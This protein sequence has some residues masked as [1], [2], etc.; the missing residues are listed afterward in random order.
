M[1]D[2][3]LSL[4]KGDVNRLQARVYSIRMSVIPLLQRIHSAN[5]KSIADQSF[6][7]L[8][9]SLFEQVEALSY[10]IEIYVGRLHSTPIPARKGTLGYQQT[11]QFHG[12]KGDLNDRLKRLQQYI[13]DLLGEMKP[14]RI[15]HR[16]KTY[17][18]VQHE[19]FELLDEVDYNAFRNHDFIEQVDLVNATIALIVLIIKALKKK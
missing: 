15:R 18:E 3:N 1:I 2:Q 19:T 14:Y 12:V 16:N 17:Q 9:H 4:L 6:V 13:K 10:T 7:K 8:S 11:Q 5:E